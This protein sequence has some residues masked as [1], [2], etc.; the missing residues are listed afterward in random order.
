MIKSPCINICKINDKTNLCEGC[1]RNM[2]EIENWSFYTD[3]EKLK[4]LVEFK[5]RRNKWNAIK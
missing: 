1:C 5:K 4:L 2:K 3:A